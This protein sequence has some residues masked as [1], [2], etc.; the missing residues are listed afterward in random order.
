[1][2]AMCLSNR[3]CSD[4]S[5]DS[6]CVWPWPDLP[7]CSNDSTPP[8]QPT[9]PPARAPSLFPYSAFGAGTKPGHARDVE[10]DDH[11][12]LPVASTAWFTLTETGGQQRS[13]TELLVFTYGNA[14]DEIQGD[15][16]FSP[17]R[18]ST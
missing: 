12:T 3:F 1:M 13:W 17:N 16:V 14:Q 18:R 4:R 8:T 5:C 10:C 2:R 11:R 9:S 6:S 7:H 15:G